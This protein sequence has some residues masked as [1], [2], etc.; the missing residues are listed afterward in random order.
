MKTILQ[1]IDHLRHNLPNSHGGAPVLVCGEHLHEYGPNELL[2]QLHEEGSIELLKV[3]KVEEDG[4]DDGVFWI[5]VQT[6]FRGVPP[7]EHLFE[8]FGKK[9]PDLDSILEKIKNSF[10]GKKRY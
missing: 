7:V 3:V 2:V 1:I 4:M 10:K 5:R 9:A 8:Q 6:R